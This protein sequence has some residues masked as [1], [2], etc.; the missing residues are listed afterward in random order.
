MQFLNAAFLWAGFAILIPPIIHLFNFRRYKTVYFS[1]V[2]FLQNMKN[3]TRQRSTLRQIL[4]MVLRM[5][6]IAMLVIAF[7][8]PVIY[9]GSADK[10]A[11]RK[12]APPII[13]IDNSFSMQAGAISGLNLETAKTKALEIVDAFPNG[14]E[15]MLITNDFEQRH[16]RL[17]KADG[18]RLFLQDITTSPRVPTIEQV[19]ERA[20]SSLSLQDVDPGCARSIF[21]ISDFQKSICEFAHEQAD[22]LLSINLVEIGADRQSNLAIDT[23]E[24]LT[25]F[26]M[27]GGEEEISVTIHN[28]GTRQVQ[29]VPVKLTINGS[30]KINETIS[31]NPLERKKLSMKYVNTSVNAVNGKVSIVDYPIDYDNSLYFSY[32]IDSVKNILLLG[33]S[34]SDTKYIRALF[35]RDRNFAITEIPQNTAANDTRLQD[36]H[37]VIL[38]GLASVD[39]AMA[40]RIQAYVAQ[41][42]NAIF[43]PAE[44]GNIDDYNYLLSLM[45]CNS[46]VSADTIRCKVSGINIQ[47]QLL[48]GAVKQIPD[49]PDLPYITRYY[50]S[51]SNSYQGEEVVLETD[52]YKKVMTSNQYRAG[53][54]FVFYAPLNERCGNLATHRVI[55]PILYNAASTSQNF[56]Q[57]YYSVIGHDNG[58]SV[59]LYGTPDISRIIMRPQDSDN[60][61]IP[62]ISGPDAYMNYK[63]F[64]EGCVDKAGFIN[65][66]VEGQV[67][68]SIAYNYDRRESDMEFLSA[69]ELANILEDKGYQA[70]R[71]MESS[72]STFAT[73]AAESAS[74]Q[75]MWRLFVIL[76]L[77]FAL[78]ELC[79]ARFMQ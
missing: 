64:S 31:M 16:N 41:G 55:V 38:C 42:G 56:G 9:K 4:L 46:I 79:V 2:R 5:L 17:A 6:V 52:T 27:N 13:Y 62:R 14:T 68:E 15:F 19:I 8:E 25:P 33:A 75:P 51:M 47:S 78:A 34:P 76:A 73:E 3:I 21:I 12:P 26:R 28:Y 54:M 43:I 59:R 20:N 7:A 24:F 22:S 32:S 44:H 49:N 58:F 29:D 37:A 53:R 66:V 36:Y 70:V 39:H 65:L 57:Q 18:I 61:F 72:S 23:I 71:V 1:D 50:N 67:K 60:E 48:R 40:N 45:E 74:T 69:N 35:G 77:T 63:I 30:V 10:T 11:I